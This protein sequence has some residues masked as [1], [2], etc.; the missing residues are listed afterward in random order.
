M[1]FTSYKQDQQLPRNPSQPRLKAR[2][3]RTILIELRK[4]LILARVSRSAVSGVR[5]SAAPSPPAASES[6]FPSCLSPDGNETE[7][8]YLILL[9]IT[10]TILPVTFFK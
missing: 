2:P 10:S 5:L 1:R 9:P 6:A 7:R 8:S 4:K 3:L